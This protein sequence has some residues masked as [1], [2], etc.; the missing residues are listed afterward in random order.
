MDPMRPTRLLASACTF[1][2][3]GALVLGLAG[4]AAAAPDP[5]VDALVTKR[6]DNPRLGGNVAVLAVDAATGEVVSDHASGQRMLP[7]SNMKIVTAGTALA[8]L[9]PDARFVTRTRSGA[10]PTDV[11]LE[12]GGDPLLS[13]RDLRR[14]AT[15]TATALTA[16]GVAPGTPLVL[17]VD[18][19][20]FPD[21]GR[22]PGWTRSYIPS[23]AASVEALARV[24]DYSRDPSANA[25]A[26]VAKRLSVKGFPTTIGPDADAGEAPVLA[27]TKG[28]TVADAVRV[29]L[30][31]S[32]NNVAEVLYRHVARAAGQPADWEG[33][34]RAAEQVLQGLGIDVTGM[35]LDDG[36]GLSR[37]NR[38]TPRFLVDVLRVARVTNPAPFT[39]MFEED[40]MPIAGRTGTL[41]DR[42]GRF[43]TKQSRCAQG[44]VL[45]KTGTLFDTIGLSGVAGTTTG[46]ERIFSILVN[47]RPQRY[48]ALSTRQAVDGL[49]ATITGCWD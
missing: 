6:L 37:T 24:W 10:T 19:D 1:T 49:T 31:I 46:G 43:T 36:S 40:A 47:D 42:Y 8:A 44:T 29:M 15:R 34:R 35:A 33:S 39:L 48:P 13:T 27:E 23:V 32:E 25:A 21:T 14:L 9:G 5:S 22:G 17:H 26:V 16:A 20:L 12:G 30:R 4:P 28:H 38:V 2:L 11:V 18:D 3:A 7:A 41:D 45:A